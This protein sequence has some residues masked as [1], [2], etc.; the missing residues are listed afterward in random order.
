M[1]LYVVGMD[2]KTPRLRL[3]DATNKVSKGRGGGW[4][5]RPRAA[6]KAKN[7]GVDAVY[8]SLS[9]V[10]N[11]DV[12]YE[13]D[14]KKGHDDPLSCHGNVGRVDV[15][16]LYMLVCRVFHYEYFIH[17]VSRLF[18]T[19]HQLLNLAV[20]AGAAT[21]VGVYPFFDVENKFVWNMAMVRLILIVSLVLGAAARFVG[22]ASNP[23]SAVPWF[24][25]MKTKILDIPLVVYA[26]LSILF[27]R[28]KMDTYNLAEGLFA[29]LVVYVLLMAYV[30]L[31]HTFLMRYANRLK[32]CI[33]AY[34]PCFELKKYTPW[35]MKRHRLVLLVK[36]GYLARLVCWVHAIR[37]LSREHV[38]DGGSIAGGVA[39]PL[40]E[41]IKSNMCKYCTAVFAGME[42]RPAAARA[43]GTA[44]VGGCTCDDAPCDGPTRYVRQRL[45]QDNGAIAETTRR[46]YLDHVTGNENID[47]NYVQAPP[48]NVSDNDSLNK[49][50]SNTLAL[51]NIHQE[52]VRRESG[53][54][55]MRSQVQHLRTQHPSTRRFMDSIGLGATEVDFSSPPVV[56]SSKAPRKYYN[57]D[58][59]AD[60]SNDEEEEEDEMTDDDE[61]EEPKRQEEEILNIEKRLKK[62]T[63]QELQNIL[64]EDRLPTGAPA[65][66]PPTAN[67]P[68]DKDMSQAQLVQAIMDK[69]APRPS[70]SFDGDFGTAPGLT[71]AVRR[72]IKVLNDN[73]NHIVDSS[74]GT[75]SKHNRVGGM[76]HCGASHDLAV[77]SCYK[78]PY[79]GR[80]Q[81]A[82][83]HEVRDVHYGLQ[84]LREQLHANGVSVV[85]AVRALPTKWVPDDL[86]RT[87]SVFAHTWHVNLTTYMCFGVVFSYLLH[88]IMYNHD[89]QVAPVMYVGAT[90]SYMYAL[91]VF[92][93]NGATLVTSCYMHSFVTRSMDLMCIAAG[94]LSCNR[95]F[96]DA[97]GNAP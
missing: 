5:G 41:S 18:V 42:Q 27:Y 65:V 1:I 31:G 62:L 85:E 6:A 77:C 46:E 67:A 11:E 21:L 26:N 24:V 53:M 16:W 96:T 82:K 75:A 3:F 38:G 45:R 69:T 15:S 97:L 58:T 59:T 12:V 35:G 56:S 84:K 68:K 30:G 90:L 57:T 29:V 72:R 89:N 92:V 39:Y 88:F 95:L 81:I 76:G 40:I 52:V 33:D 9:S 36:S 19:V 13:R 20:I 25:E 14:A 50:L 51:M 91:Y 78:V 43:T 4:G 55:G 23:E 44:G 32:F 34:G 10:D 66:A 71:K 28:N 79:L 37:R 2:A 63:K 7:G 93:Y 61:E 70:S 8:V 48:V 73:I 86:Y 80:R 83:R 74:T 64:K 47:L 17:P 22:F 87:S 54:K 49:A 60:G 94:L